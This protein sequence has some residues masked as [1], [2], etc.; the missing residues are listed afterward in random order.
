MN[1]LPYGYRIVG[2]TSEERRLVDASA[3]FAGYAS[4]DPRAEIRSES[5]LSAFCFGADFRQLLES[6]GSIRG[7]TGPCWAPWIW[8]DI[9]HESDLERALSD[10]RRLAGHLLE[11]F[12]TVDDRDLLLF[13]S[14]SKGFHVGLPTPAWGPAPSSTFHRVARRFASRIAEEVGIITDGG[15]Y[16]Q[17]RAFRA[18]NSRHPKTGQFKCRLAVEELM[19]LSLDRILQLAECPK[20]FDLSA[21]RGQSA[22]AAADWRMAEDW[23]REQAEVKA[24]RCAVG[25][26]SALTRQTLAFIRDGAAVGDRHRLLFSAAANLGKFDCPPD[27]AHALLTEAALDSGLCPSEIRRQISCGLAHAAKVQGGT[28]GSTP[29]PSTRDPAGPLPAISDP[30]AIRVQLAALWAFSTP[31]PQLSSPSLPSVLQADSPHSQSQDAEEPDTWQQ[32][33]AAKP[34][35]PPGERLFYQD[36]RCRPCT[37][38]DAYLWTWAGAREWFY[39][40]DHPVPEGISGGWKQ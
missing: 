33:T 31:P 21:F 35:P 18:P 39:A 6:T 25:K 11:R 16:D 8:W 12:A 13:Y 15:I 19:A 34:A 1:S 26:E 32:G 17:T 7:F 2:P 28:A 20:P 24:R 38:A 30:A 27:L 29:M 22:H 9:D 36:E 10:T 4:C 5:Y 3:A 40:A 37:P 23:V 14:G